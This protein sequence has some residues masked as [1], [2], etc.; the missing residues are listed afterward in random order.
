MS[1]EAVFSAKI[2]GVMNCPFFG[3]RSVSVTPRATEHLPQTKMGTPFATAVSSI[4]LRGAIATG[5]TAAATS[6]FM[7]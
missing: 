7:R 3:F 1:A 2:L 4:S 5:I 6:S